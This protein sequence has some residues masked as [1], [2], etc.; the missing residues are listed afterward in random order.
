M[1]SVKR[2]IVFIVNSLSSPPTHWDKSPAA[3]G[4]IA[5]LI[6]ATG[7]PIDHYSFEAV[8]LM[9]D[10]EARWRLFREISGSSAFNPSRD[11]TLDRE[12]RAPN[13]QLYAI[14]VSFP[15]LKDPTEAAYLNDLPTS[16]ALPPEAVDR[17]RAAAA[18]IVLESPEFSRLLKDVGARI[19]ENV[20]AA[21]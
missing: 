11:P 14:D 13:T 18:K 7:V 5:L 6:K 16:F 9:K 4:D 17:L 15:Q 2:V 1:D 20:P 21:H 19:V 3:P 12:V 10:I 8:E